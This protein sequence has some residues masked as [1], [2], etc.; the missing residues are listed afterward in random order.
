MTI[1]YKIFV[2]NLDRSPE[3]MVKIGEQLASFNLP[4][5]R[6]SAVDGKQL[7][8]QELEH[9]APSAMVAKSYHR[10]LGA[11]EV[12]C[13]LSHKNIWQ[14]IVD[15]QL[16][17]AFIIEDDIELKENF[18]DAV[19]MVSKIAHERWDFFKLFPLSRGSEKNIDQ[20][21]DYNGFTFVTYH[22]FPLGTQGQVVSLQGAKKMLA[23][24]P[25]ILQPIDSQ[26]KSWWELDIFPFGLLPYCVYDDVSIGSDI[27]PNS[28]LE[29]MP[30][31]KGRKIWNK[32]KKGIARMISHPKLNAEFKAF[33][34]ALEQK[35]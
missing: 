17:F 11:G 14:K 33:Q 21:F 8:E 18:G 2:I 22:K 23:N 16:D 9:H 28:K 26:I 34:S 12:G 1:K 27:N 35:S 4:Y 32:I 20:R 6:I 24:M 5:E 7:S 13:S 25:H 10:Q 3:R 29:Q 31:N 30:Q 19:E 15:E